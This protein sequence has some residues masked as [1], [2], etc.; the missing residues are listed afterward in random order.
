MF[1]VLK[2]LQTHPELSRLSLNFDWSKTLN[3]SVYKLVYK[4]AV[5]RFLGHLVCGVSRR[6]VAMVTD[7]CVRDL[8]LF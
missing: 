1:C 5:S 6:R 2:Q 7:F 8:Y 4:Q 3:I